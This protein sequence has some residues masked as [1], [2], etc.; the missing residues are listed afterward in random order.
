MQPE[1]DEEEEKLE[2]EPGS[3]AE[4]KIG[5]D[6]SKSGQHTPAVE[7]EDEEEEK[8]PVHPMLIPDVVENDHVEKAELLPPK[9]PEGNNALVPDLIISENRIVAILEKALN[10]VCEW[11]KGE[12]KVYNQKTK[13]EGKQLKD[14]SVEELD[15]NLRKQWPRK[16]RL[17]VEIF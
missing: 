9:D 12:M 5:D 2:G 1:K 11:I 7:G 15:E 10:I 8:G 13:S 16:G 3:D 14:Q 17:E 6:T 4:S